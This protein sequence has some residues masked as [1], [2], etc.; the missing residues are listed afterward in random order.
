MAAFAL[1]LVNAQLANPADHLRF[2]EELLATGSGVIRFWETDQECVVLGRSGRSERDVNL[3]ECLADSIP[4]LQRSSGGGAILL[5][6][7]CLNYTLVLPLAWH[8]AWRDVRYSLHWTMDRILR[9]LLIPGLRY[10]GD[11]DLALDARKVSGNAQR[12]TQSAILHHGTILYGFDASRA[13]RFLRPPN[14]QPQY[15]AGRSHLDFLGNI[16]LDARQIRE[17]LMDAWC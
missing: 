12:R 1:S 3:E 16:P 13:E 6:P 17:R 5:G 15:R 9:A 11:C 10:E 8:S 4:V 2:D 7:G 14:R